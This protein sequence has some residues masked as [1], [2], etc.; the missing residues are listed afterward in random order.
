MKKKIL[1]STPHNSWYRCFLSLDCVDDDWQHGQCSNIVDEM[2]RAAI[3]RTFNSFNCFNWFKV[4]TSISSKH[5]CK[6]F[7]LP[8]SSL[9]PSLPLQHSSYCRYARHHYHV[10]VFH[11]LPR[12]C[13]GG[14]LDDVQAW[15]T[16]R[17][18]LHKRQGRDVTQI[19]AACMHATCSTR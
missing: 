4:G 19:N 14:P 15:C 3:F 1:R 13:A 12:R 17:C 7:H 9:P 6:Q 5:T 11:N 18:M 16:A 8:L 2:H 10:A